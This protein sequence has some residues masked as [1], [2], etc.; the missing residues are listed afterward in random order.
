MD[1][2]FTCLSRWLAPF[3]CFTA[4]EAYLA[5]HPGSSGSVHLEQFPDL[6]ANWRDEALAAR[7]SVIRDIRRV[8]TGALE[9]ERAAKRIGS[10]LQAAPHL[11][12]AADQA[13]ALAGIDLEEICIISGLTVSVA[14]PPADAFQIDEIAGV[15]VQFAAA[16]GEKC[17]RCWRVL[18]DVGSHAHAGLC[19][20]CD[21]VIGRSEAK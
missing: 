13:A 21:D 14:P 5:R 11:Y 7:W 12:I 2:I 4:E 15:G 8:V 17:A 16:E 1:V 9:L 6:P 3:L 19:A 20:R 18:P 10:S